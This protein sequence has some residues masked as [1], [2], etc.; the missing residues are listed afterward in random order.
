[1]AEDD[2]TR[3]DFVA[4][5][6]AGGLI[7]AS[8]GVPQL[9]HVGGTN[10]AISEYAK[11]DGVG[12]AE[13]VRKKRVKPEELL[14]EAIRQAEALNPHLNCIV[15]KNYDRARDAAKG[16]VALGVF[17]GVP[18][19][20]KD[21]LGYAQGMP[22]REASRFYP[23]TPWDHDSVIVS[24][25][26]A[27]GLIAFGKT[28]VPELVLSATT[29][30]D[31]YGPARN[32]WSL[33]HSTGGSSGG[34]A[35]AVAAGIVPLAHGADGGG[36]IRIPA[37]CCGLVGLKP[38]RGRTSYAPDHGDVCGTGLK[39]KACCR[40]ACATPQRRW[41]SSRGA[42]QETPTRHPWVRIPM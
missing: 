19:L 5:T 13:L 35:A 30:S 10:V 40:A 31:L 7:G 14:D 33:E 21:S 18:F 3:R 16:Q 25:F 39:Y 34:S 1:M 22:T 11:F 24:R 32:P 9:P 29:E 20:L 37:S 41:T 12:L 23:A 28:N 15:F 38:T 26:K 4:M 2:I 36:S 27:A 6:V 8:T 42:L 17:A